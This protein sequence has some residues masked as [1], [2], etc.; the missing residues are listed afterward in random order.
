MKKVEVKAVD[1]IKPMNQATKE[2]HEFNKIVNNVKQTYRNIEN[3][4]SAVALVVVSVYAASEASKHHFAMKYAREAVLFCAALIAL[5]G[6]Y[7]LWKH[8]NHKAK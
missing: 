5:Q 7:L 1:N 8:I 2:R 3:F 4:I 6:F